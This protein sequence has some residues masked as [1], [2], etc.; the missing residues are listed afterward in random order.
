MITTKHNIHSRKGQLVSIRWMPVFLFNLNWSK[1]RIAHGPYPL[2][3]HNR[4]VN[5]I[6]FFETPV[7][8]VTLR[9]Q[10]ALPKNQKME[11]NK[12]VHDY[13]IYCCAGSGNHKVTYWDWVLCYVTSCSYYKYT[14]PT[15]KCSYD[16]W[17]PHMKP[18]LRSLFIMKTFISEISLQ[19]TVYWYM[20]RK[21]FCRW[22]CCFI[23]NKP[24]E[25]FWWLILQTNLIHAV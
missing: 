15:S 2:L 16:T 6:G 5:S 19:Q 25:V 11:R 7:W 9:C 12:T 24:F 8:P 1:T 20:G 21:L 22:N 14:S 18:S 13:T 3:N 17:I 4:S 23:L 10:F